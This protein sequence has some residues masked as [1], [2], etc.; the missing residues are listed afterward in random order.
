MGLV[1]RLEHEATVGVS[2]T[3]SK[4][5]KQFWIIFLWIASLVASR[6]LFE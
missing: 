6:E 1:Q 5:P 2:A 3:T 4:A